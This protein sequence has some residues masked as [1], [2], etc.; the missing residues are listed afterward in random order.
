MGDEEKE[1]DPK[2][3]E[4]FN[5]CSFVCGSIEKNLSIARFIDDYKSLTEQTL[6]VTEYGFKNVKE[7]LLAN[8][9]LQQVKGPNNELLFT[10][11]PN[12]NNKIIR[13]MVMEQK[14]SND[15]SNKRRGSKFQNMRRGI[16]NRNFN[17]HVNRR[18]NP[19][20]SN[21]RINQKNVMVSHMSPKVN[22][23]YN[24]DGTVMRNV[25]GHLMT[26]HQAS[27]FL[28]KH[29]TTAPPN[30]S[31]LPP[32]F[33]PQ[34]FLN[35]VYSP[36][37]NRHQAPAI[38][39]LPLKDAVDIRTNKDVLNFHINYKGFDEGVPEHIPSHLKRLKSPL[40]HKFPEEFVSQVKLECATQKSDA[41]SDSELSG[42]ER[43]LGKYDSIAKHL[44]GNVS[45]G[46]G[47]E[48]R[49]ESFDFKTSNNK[50]KQRTI[51]DL[52][53]YETFCE[54]FSRCDLREWTETD[55]I[56]GI[57]VVSRPFVCML[58]FKI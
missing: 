55:P 27:L 9:K 44:F 8:P 53:E 52:E 43:E 49:V 57:S 48:K 54:R 31:P 39:D 20:Y 42:N 58:D 11:K 28:N 26:E 51:L 3:E 36:N 4:F 24:S 17:S 45:I 5:D 41:A 15:Y 6:D 23:A 10:L 14:P 38:Q 35:E 30:C 33:S 21:G 16:H 7:A 13:K 25:R 22:Y 34:D 2:L 12:K 18:I 19:P 46:G 47:D 32:K 1:V 37:N 56:T 50:T 40:I 29:A